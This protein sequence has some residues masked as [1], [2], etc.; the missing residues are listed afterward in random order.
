MLYKSPKFNLIM[1]KDIENLL[2]SLPEP[3][4]IPLEN[5]IIEGMDLGKSQ[6]RFILIYNRNNRKYYLM[7]KS[8]SLGI[9]DGLMVHILYDDEFEDLKTFCEEYVLRGL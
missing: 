2:D 7:R 1:N 6:Q 3:E 5:N 9:I 8:K 4:F